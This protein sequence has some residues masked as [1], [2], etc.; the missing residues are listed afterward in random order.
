MSQLTLYVPLFPPGFGVFLRRSRTFAAQPCR[1]SCAATRQRQSIGRDVLGDDAARSD[2]GALADL[3]RRDERGVG[4]DEG[5]GADLGAMLGEAVI[6]AGDG[7]GADV[8]A[9][10]DAGIADIGEMV[11]LG[12]LADLGLLDLDEIADMRVLGE[13][14]RR[15]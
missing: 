14:E 13:A 11:N 9:R 12:A 6:V 2:I 1:S 8:S 15:A 5:V 7:A 3:D 4:A 10:A